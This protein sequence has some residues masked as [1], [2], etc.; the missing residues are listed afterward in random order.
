MA[1]N[2]SFMEYCKF[3]REQKTLSSFDNGTYNDWNKCWACPKVTFS[4]QVTF[5]NF[6]G[7]KTAVC[8]FVCCIL[9]F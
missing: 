2:G 5:F 8:V 3:V 9:I 6:I 4:F 7:T 1:V